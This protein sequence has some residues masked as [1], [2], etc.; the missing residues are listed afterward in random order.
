MNWYRNL[1]AT[2]RLIIGFGIT[3]A[4]T[5][6]LSGLAISSLGAAN[7]RVAALYQA[8]LK[9]GFMADALAYSQTT[10]GKK[11]RDAI[12][13]MDNPEIVRADEKAL[14]AEFVSIHADLA[15][16]P[17]YFYSPEG[18][19]TLE[20]IA[21]ALPIYEQTYR[22][23]IPYLDARD[24]RGATIALDK[25]TKVSDPLVAALAHAKAIKR[26][27][28]QEKFETNEREYQHARTLI[29]SSAALSLLL[30]A[31][32]SIVIARGFSVPL[33]YAVT[34]LERMAGGDLTVSL[35]I[36]TKDEVGRMAA[37]LND[38]IEKLRSTLLDVTEGARSAGA[39]SEEL[40]AAADSLSS[41]AQEQAASLE[42]TSASLEQVAATV[43]QSADGAREANQLA[44]ASRGEAE[45]G[46]GVVTSAIKAMEEI[47][48]ASSK[49]SNIISTID[50]IAFQT[51]L[52]AVNAAVEAARAGEQGR[53]FAV[54]ATEVR[55]LAQRSAGAAKEIKHLIE[56][57]LAKVER[58][59]GLVNRSGETLQSI[60]VSVKK[61]TD[62]VSEISKAV[63][64]Q[65]IGI[66][67]VNTAVTQIDQVTQSNAA[68]TEQ[69]SSTA[70]SLAD[71]SNHL[72]KLVSVFTL[73]E[74]DLMES[75][76]ATRPKPQPRALP[77]P[78]G[79][80][81]RSAYTSK[82]HVQDWLTQ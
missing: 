71:Q 31:I 43:R 41:G 46:Q 78:R 82:A 74:E 23:V 19:A 33:G 53:G 5:L 34:T 68:Q 50:E 35:A 7:D 52:L 70:R 59:A 29:L 49:I 39:A 44:S 20:A 38:T 61:V 10:I 42:E 25:T 21:S 64:E 14:L 73:G 6:I 45:G 81:A 55:S 18:K 28:A 17:Q 54:V 30:G 11:S 58:G 76:I 77:K 80:K 75:A 3:L 47:N 26:Q 69:L 1:D 48:H 24:A 40:A 51:N 65:T 56:D 22:A 57:S 13:H 16:A 60:V 32:L 72:M 4:L 37:A 8:D 36:D 67:Q 9:G 79:T 62:V 12:V 27:R 2:H 66:D 63:D 15:Q